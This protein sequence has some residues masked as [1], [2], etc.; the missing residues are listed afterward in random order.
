MRKNQT[1]QSGFA[2]PLVAMVAF[3][4]AILIFSIFQTTEVST[5]QMLYF[6]NM[7][8]VYRLAESGLSSALG[9][10][11]VD[12]STATI[13]SAGSIEMEGEGVYDNFATPV[14]SPV[15]GSYYIV[16]SAT[17][18][19][20]G[21]TYACKLHT[22]AAVANVGDYFAAFQ[23]E[24]RL[25]AGMNA[26]GGKIYAPNLVFFISTAV[27]IRTEA[28]E[29]EYFFAA[30]AQDSI[31]NTTY[32]NPALWSS[33]NLFNG[34][35]IM[36]TEIFI[37]SDTVSIL[38]TKLPTLRKFPQVSSADL[39]R[40]SDLAGPH[41]FTNNFAGNVF[42]PGYRNGGT[43]D[44]LP[45]DNYA[46]HSCDNQDHIY[47]SPNS[48]TIGSPGVE[49]KIHGQILFVSAQHINIV[50]NIVSASTNTDP[51]PGAGNTTNH[52]S[53]STAHQAVL[54]TRND[55]IITP[56][57]T[58][59]STRT[60]QAFLFAPNGQLTVNVGVSTNAYN[61]NFTGS[62]ILARGTNPPNNLPSQF[63]GTRTYQYMTT[64]KTNPPPYLPALAEIFYSLEDITGTP[65]V[66]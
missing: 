65:G 19:S 14:S 16:T 21:K 51:M 39:Q 1:N 13:N 29:A 15:A 41:N 11:S 18:T 28:L 59:G 37:G 7:N 2:L 8:R 3:G 52:A 46:G 4:L 6:N 61:F 55:I 56:P 53:S 50:G 10:L 66:F 31:T 23:Q 57:T 20:G 40:Y 22:Y 34:Q 60:V 58:Y 9:Q 5:Q 45:G 47:Y 62:E 38:P 44:P 27:P 42:P 33:I 24:F 43:C 64:L 35:P 63:T 17:R 12:P 26:A 49:T 54:I 25:S 48:I 32:P 30:T 36:P